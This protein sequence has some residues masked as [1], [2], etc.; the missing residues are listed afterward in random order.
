MSA[1]VGSA[2]VRVGSVGALVGA[3]LAILYTGFISGADAITKLI[4]GGY[5]APQLFAFSGL[6]VIASQACVSPAPAPPRKASA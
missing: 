4:A 2:A 3:G 1:A 5:A 6:I